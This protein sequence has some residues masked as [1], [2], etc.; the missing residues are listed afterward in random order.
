MSWVQRKWR[1]GRRRRRRR[2]KKKKKREEGV[3]G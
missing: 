1:M 3:A 2:S